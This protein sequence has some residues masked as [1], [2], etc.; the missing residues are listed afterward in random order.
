MCCEQVFEAFHGLDLRAHDYHRA[1]IA[2][3]RRCLQ[4]GTTKGLRV[5]IVTASSDREAQKSLKNLVGGGCGAVGF[6]VDEHLH[7]STILSKITQRRNFSA[8]ELDS[9][10]YPKAQCAVI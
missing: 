5:R 2:A 3:L 1:I 9:K 7:H 6:V 8:R 10:A 4:K